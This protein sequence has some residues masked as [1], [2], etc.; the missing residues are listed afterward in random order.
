MLTLCIVHNFD[1][2][3]VKSIM[4]KI[5]KVRKIGARENFILENCSSVLCF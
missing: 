4:S 3:E 2:A 5:S 1:V